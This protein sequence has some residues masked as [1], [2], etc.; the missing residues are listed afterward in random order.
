MSLDG[1]NFGTGMSTMFL[2]QGQFDLAFIFFHVVVCDPETG[3]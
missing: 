1:E 3:Y 2:M